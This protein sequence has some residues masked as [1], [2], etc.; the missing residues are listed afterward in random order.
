MLASLDSA[1]LAKSTSDSWRSGHPKLER[2][3]FAEFSPLLRSGVP[4]VQGYDEAFSIDRFDGEPLGDAAPLEAYIRLL[5]DS[6]TRRGEVPV[7]KFCRSLGRLPWFRRVFDDAVHIVVEKNPVS[8]WQSCRDLMTAHGN[9]HFVAVPFAVLAF[10]RDVPVVARVLD[11]LQVALPEVPDAPQGS[12]VGHSLAFFKQYVAGIAPVDAYRAFLAHW[13]LTMRHAATDAHAIFDCDLAAWSPAWLARAEQWT[14]ELTGLQ[15]SFA[16]MDN[17]GRSGRDCGF[18][19]VEGLRIHLDVMALA[20]DLASRG[21]VH[22]DTAAFW[23][24]KIAQATQVQAFG[25][26]AIWPR[27]DGVPSLGTRIARVALIDGVDTDA[28]LLAEL[29]AT[30]AA[31][32]RTRREKAELEKPVTARLLA[33]LRWPRR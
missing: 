20:E 11:A 13:L 22:A 27:D 23:T 12:Q 26:Q 25:A 28:A 32:S 24:S 33:R 31:L 29:R 14:T 4:G 21:D 19:A 17:G 2:P 10:N 15:P 16:T 1:M 3:Y 18:D 6:A 8:Q 30:Q 9:A 5:I 7:F